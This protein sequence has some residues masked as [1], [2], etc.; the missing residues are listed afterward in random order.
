[1]VPGRHAGR[2]AG[3]DKLFQRVAIDDSAAAT[4]APLAVLVDGQ[5]ASAAEI[6][7]G[8]VLLRGRCTLA[9]STLHTFFL[10]GAVAPLGRPLVVIP[11]WFS[12]RPWMT[13]CRIPD[14]RVL[15][16]LLAAR[17]T[18]GPAQLNE[19]SGFSPRR[20]AF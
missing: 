6:L 17:R 8:A 7:A 20:F 1:M 18:S 4:R 12:V 19:Q 14:R 16:K 9:H 3:A 15:T 10:P 2:G 13:R 5:S 11:S